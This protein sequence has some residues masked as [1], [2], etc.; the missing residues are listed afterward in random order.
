MK[1]HIVLL[2]SLVGL[3]SCGEGGGESI[4]LYFINAYAGA[5]NVTVIGPT[6][7]MVQGAKFGD[8]VGVDSS[9]G[10][11]VC[12]PGKSC[13]PLQFD[14][15]LGGDFTAII[16]GAPETYEFS[17]PLFSLYPQ[18]TATMLFGGRSNDGNS[19]EGHLVRHTQ[20][21]SDTCVLT[22]MNALSLDTGNGVGQ[23]SFDIVPEFNMT[24]EEA[25]YV[26]E[27]QTILSTECGPMKLPNPDY[28]A[29]KDL[30]ADVA[31]NPWF[32]VAKC[33][34]IDETEGDFLCTSWVDPKTSR[35][36]ALDLNSSIWARRN[37][38]EY[39]G[40]IANAISFQDDSMMMGAAGDSCPA[41]ELAWDDAALS[42]DFKK[43]A[44]CQ[45]FVSKTVESVSPDQSRYSLF[46][47]NFRND[48]CT[49]TFRFRT[50]G[51]DAVFGPETDSKTKGRHQKGELVEISAEIGPG[52]EY[53][54]AIMGRPV[55]PIIWRWESGT[56]I[57]NLD[58]FPYSNDQDDRIGDY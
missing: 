33:A 28:I 42:I 22:F 53:F 55:N 21:I 15:N 49:P 57:A 41:G 11:T 48:L 46:G 52:N 50:P 58:D 7:P 29:R 16:D 45:E 6:G 23:Q 3:S 56:N 14:R 43:I 47:S 32:F 37:T 1:L 9:G 12:E 26:D 39:F 40:C 18:E 36:G 25:L 38:E 19:V 54:V 20:T 31:E 27:T 34:D 8:R 2:I 13:I 4:F 35:Y 10:S 44:D 30:M 51:L 24:P 17:Y 5:D